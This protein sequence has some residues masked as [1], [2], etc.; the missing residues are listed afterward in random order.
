MAV[1]YSQEEDRV[2]IAVSRTALALAVIALHGP[3]DVGL[4]LLAWHLEANPLVLELGPIAWI[5]VKAAALLALP[6]ALYGVDRDPW[7]PGDRL[8]AGHADVIAAGLLA[9]TVVL[10]TVLVVPNL[11]VI[12]AA[13]GG[14]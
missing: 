5:G 8:V 4:T 7:L 9:L 1:S 14:A 10:G 3:L 13:G 11:V 2:H 6:V 12:A